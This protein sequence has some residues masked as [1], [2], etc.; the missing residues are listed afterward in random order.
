[1]NHLLRCAL[2]LALLSPL[3]SATY[4]EEPLYRRGVNIAGAEFGEVPGKIHQNYTYNNEETFKYFGEKGFNVLRV[5][6]SWERFQPVLSGP[7][8]AANLEALKKNV[9]W[10]KAH[11]ST[12]IIDVHNYCRYR[13]STGGKPVGSIIDVEKDGKIAVKT[14]DLADLWVRLSSEFKDEPAVYG[15]GLMNEPHDLGTA[16]W[17]AISN[18]VVKAIR[19]SGDK[20][21]IL[22]GGVHWSN[23]SGWE[24]NNGPVNW[25]TDPENN[26]IYEAHCY[27]D[28]DNSGS[29][30][31]SYDKELESNPNLAVVGRER[32]KGFIEWCKKNNVRGFLGEFAIPGDDP[33]WNEVLENFMQSL[34]EAGFGGTYWAAGTFWGGYPMSLQ[35]T[36][37]YTADRPQLTVLLKHLSK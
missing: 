22:V 26:I 10:A 4:A 30:K 2:G 12:V 37:K 13:V 35:P 7:L 11:G 33:R 29:Y 9:A 5:P 15:Y 24:K 20:R 32:L 17:K 34:D 23:A 25:I 6:I 1:M 31:K 3:L 21:V 16:D 36:Q 8:D 27:F 14:A 19:D 28:H 18:A